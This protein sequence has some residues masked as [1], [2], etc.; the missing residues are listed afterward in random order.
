[1]VRGLV[2]VG[3]RD[4]GVDHVVEALE[5]GGGSEDRNR[6]AGAAAALGDGARTAVRAVRVERDHGAEA[7]RPARRRPRGRGTYRR[8][9]TRGGEARAS[10][11]ADT[12]GAA[13]E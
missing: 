13:A 7:T 3:D 5:L 10:G 8:S 1:R 2:V 11:T 4:R 9:G 12:T 6:D